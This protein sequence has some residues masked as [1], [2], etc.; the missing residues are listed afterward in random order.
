MRLVSIFLSLS[1]TSS[2]I[3]QLENNRRLSLSPKISWNAQLT[4]NELTEA[5][6]TRL[7]NDKVGDTEMVVFPEPLVN[8]S[9][10]VGPS[11][12]LVVAGAVFIALVGFRNVAMVSMVSGSL[13]NAALSKVLKRLIAQERPGEGPG[14]MGM[15]SSHAMSLGFLGTYTCLALNRY[16]VTIGVLLYALLSLVYRID[17]KLH[18]IPQIVVG[19]VVG[20]L[21]GAFWFYSLTS[22]VGHVLS[23]VFVEGKLPL[24]YVSIP[25]VVGALTIGSVER[26]LGKWIAKVKV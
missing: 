2:F 3:Y 9:K 13:L 19:A 16:D 21:H 8:V 24:I 14:D 7:W 20:S 15:P 1:V 22:L 11:T 10:L 18:T 5:C 23:G 25:L 17:R 4:T 12:S 6:T 26:N